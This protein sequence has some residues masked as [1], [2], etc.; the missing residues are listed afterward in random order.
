V[1]LIFPAWDIL[2]LI[3]RNR[4]LVKMSPVTEKKLSEVKE[5]IDE[6]SLPLALEEKRVKCRNNSILYLALGSPA[7]YV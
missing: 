7:Y 2:V 1:Y 5:W 3:Y 4:H 6:F